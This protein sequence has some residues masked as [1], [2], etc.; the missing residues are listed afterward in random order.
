ML[1]TVLGLRIALIFGV[2]FAIGF[3]LDFLALTV[4]GRR[5]WAALGTNES[6]LARLAAALVIALFLAGVTTFTINDAL[7]PVNNPADLGPDPTRID[8]ARIRTAVVLLLALIACLAAAFRIEMYHRHALGITG[9][10]SEE[11]PEWI[12]EGVK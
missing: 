2:V 10:Q 5:Q 8:S 9:R 7:F 6:L 3:T 12:E 11:E 4:L 1:Q